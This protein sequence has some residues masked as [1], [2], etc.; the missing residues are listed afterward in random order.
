M[1]CSSYYLG[2]S[3]ESARE[4]DRPRLTEDSIPRGNN[5]EFTYLVTMFVTFDEELRLTGEKKNHGPPQR[6]SV[7]ISC[8]SMS[9]QGR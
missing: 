9:I 6:Y 3:P 7:D 1:N 2:A 8:F 5:T 4:D